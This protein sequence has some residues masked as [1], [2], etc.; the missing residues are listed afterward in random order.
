MHFPL[1]QWRSVCAACCLHVWVL[2]DWF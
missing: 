1:S 2:H